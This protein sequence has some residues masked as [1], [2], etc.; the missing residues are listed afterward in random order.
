M[1]E[2]RLEINRDEILDAFYPSIFLYEKLKE[3]G[4]PVRMKKTGE[5]AV[6]RGTMLYKTN[7]ERCTTVYR[8]VDSKQT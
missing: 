3:A 4:F 5:I 6:T 1:D 7:D 8:W 2:I